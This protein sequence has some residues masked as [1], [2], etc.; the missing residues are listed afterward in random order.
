VW[1]TAHIKRRGKKMKNDLLFIGLVF[2]FM[3]TVGIATV[4]ADCGCDKQPEKIA[5]NNTEDTNNVEIFDNIE[6]AITERDAKWT[7]D[8]TS[9]SK[10]SVEEKKR[11]CGVDIGFTPNGSA[12]LSRS[13]FTYTGT[14]DWRDVN[15]QNWVTSVKNQGSCGSCWIFGATAAFETQINIDANDSALDFDASEQKILS[16]LSG[17]WGCGGGDPKSALKHIRDD[18]IPNEACMPYHANDDIPCSEACSDWESNA[19]SLKTIGIPGSHTTDS[20]KAILENN[21]PMV[22]VLSVGEDLFYYKGGIYEPTWTS[23][24]FGWA[25][26][27]VMLVGYDDNNECWII[28]NSWGTGWGEDG[29]GRVSYGQLEQYTYA[30]WIEDTSGCTPPSV[31]DLEIT[32]IWHEGSKVY[33]KVKNIGE[34][35]LES[36][37]I[38]LIIDGTYKMDDTIGPLEGGEEIEES[39][40]YKWIC[41]GR[42]D[43]ITVYAD[44]EDA[45]LESDETNNSR[46]ETWSTLKAKR[47]NKP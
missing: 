5:V 44:Y 26:H 21:G 39:Y 31:I 22:V 35:T 9:V 6:R 20:Y 36:C 19:W 41:T 12:E 38:A 47:V 32:D 28:K 23:K 3:L 13:K 24:E 25:N 7:A 42:S 8:E 17:G 45:V 14:F 46:T 4:A 29:Y 16:C 1:V 40:Q 43:E 27:C 10:L 15:G 34:T 33:Y 11:L 18:G 37:N 30:F 2:V